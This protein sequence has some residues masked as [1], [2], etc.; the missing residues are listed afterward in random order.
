MTPPAAALPDGPYFHSRQSGAR[1][2]CHRHPENTRRRGAALC[3]LG[4]AA[5]TQG[6][7]L[8]VPGPRRVH[9]EVFRDRARPACAWLR[10]R[11]ARLARAGPVATRARQS[12]PRLC[13]QLRP[14]SDRPGNLHQRRCAAGLPAAGVRARPLHGRDGAAARRPRRQ[15]LVRPHGAAR[16]HDRAARDAALARQPDRGPGHA[17]PGPGINVCPRRRAHGG[18]AASVRRQPAHVRSRALRPQRRDPAGGA[19][20]RGRLADGGMD[21]RRLPRHAGNGR[22]RL[23]RQDPPAAPDPGRGRRRH[24][25]DPGD[26][27][28]LGAAARRRAPDRA[29]LPPRDADGAGPHPR[30]GIRRVRRLRAGHTAVRVSCAFVGW[31]ERA[32]ISRGGMLVSARNPSTGLAWGDTVD[33]FR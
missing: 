9:R 30:P 2:R 31:V 5:G 18:D 23:S 26:R 27:R 10:R 15:P 1:W 13:A 28:V 12:A 11:H 22:A 16:A 14:V 25:I 7:R 4:P 8:P 19:R 21:R 32:A 17:L 29:G 20:A 3:A 6:H 24:R 33:G